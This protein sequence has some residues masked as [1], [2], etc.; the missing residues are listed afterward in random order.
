M[1]GISDG[2]SPGADAKAKQRPPSAEASASAFAPEAVVHAPS[3][4]AGAKAKAKKGMA[5]IKILLDFWVA[6]SPAPF[7]LPG[8]PNKK[9]RPQ[10]PM[11]QARPCK[12]AILSSTGQKQGAGSKP[13]PALANKRQPV[14]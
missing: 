6:S 7:H 11:K 5:F 1:R 3:S 8:A 12:N 13:A 2:S 4:K 9:T 14:F 10:D